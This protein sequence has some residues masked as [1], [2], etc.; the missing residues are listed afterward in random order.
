MTSE[1]MKNTYALITG[2]A[3]GIGEALSEYFVSKGK[4]TIM[5]DRTEPTPRKRWERLNTIFLT[6]AQFRLVPQNQKLLQ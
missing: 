6:R 1:K 4:T 3:G 5:A 2:G